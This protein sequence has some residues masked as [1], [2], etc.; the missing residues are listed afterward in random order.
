MFLPSV[1]YIYSKGG[2]DPMQELGL[3]FRLEERYWPQFWSHDQSL[4]R[5]LW[6]SEGFVWSDLWLSA[7]VL[8]SHLVVN[9]DYLRP[10]A[11]GNRHFDSRG[12]V[13]HRNNLFA[14]WRALNL[15]AQPMDADWLSMP[16]RLVCAAVSLFAP[17][18][19]YHSAFEVRELR[20]V[21]GE[22]TLAQLSELVPPEIPALVELMTDSGVA[23]CLRSFDA[24]L[25]KGTISRE[26][27]Q[28]CLRT[29]VEQASED[30]SKLRGYQEPLFAFS[31]VEAI[32]MLRGRT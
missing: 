30:V 23:L 29:M 5:Q 28:I 25:A 3:K 26:T 17:E 11:H 27:Y 31:E 10:C 21:V 6:T 4:E 8:S 20:T 1:V 16:D 15:L 24:E 14:T 18:P 13:Y 7:S 9:M 32:H 12:N 19:Y 22:N 2:V